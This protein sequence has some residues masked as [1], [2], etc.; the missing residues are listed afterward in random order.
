MAATI[1]GARDKLRLLNARM[2]ELVAR[3][4]ELSVSSQSPESLDT[5]A[6]DITDLTDELEALRQAVDVTGRARA[7][8]NGCD[9][10]ASG[11]G[12]A[13]RSGVTDTPRGR[14]ADEPTRNRIASQFGG[15]GRRDRTEPGIG[16]A[17]GRRAHLRA[18]QD[19]PRRLLQPCQHRAE[20]GVR[21]AAGRDPVGD[22]GAALRRRPR[23]CRRRHHVRAV[24]HDPRR[25][26]RRDCRRPGDHT[27]TR[28]DPERDHRR[29]HTADGAASLVDIETTIG[30]ANLVL[31][32][33]LFYGVATLCTAA[34]N[35]RR[36]FGIP[37][38]TPVLNNVVT[39]AMFVAVGLI[40]GGDSEIL[41]VERYDQTTVLL[42]GLGTTAGVAA[43]EHRR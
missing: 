28:R 36:V 15:G 8:R 26:R 4:I 25:A 3:T 37:A 23:D 31:P 17:E 5:V 42:L 24:Q 32:Q 27:G 41:D 10:P 18:R 29:W 2:G 1:T 6:G 22:V 14:V 30:L 19:E 13:R 7:V 38:F 39:S 40:L 9:R 16:T 34:L 12:P 35:S 20:P 43:D 33:I 21:T 11:G